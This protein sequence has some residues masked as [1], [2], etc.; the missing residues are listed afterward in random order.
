MAQNQ[1]T[2]KKKTTTTKRKTRRTP[3]PKVYIPAYKI[4]IFCAV[5]IT[6]C[7]TL[8]LAT[9]L[10]SKP[11]QTSIS[12]RYDEEVKIEK[13]V[14]EEEK[15]KAP[16]KKE[17]PKKETVKKETKKDESVKVEVPTE[18]KVEAPKKETPKPVEKEKT[19]AKPVTETKKPTP[20][21]EEKKD[22]G[23]PQA[24]NNAQLI[25]VF[26]DGGHSLKQ[27]EKFLDL[28]FPY[29]VAVLPR[30]KFSKETASLIRNSGNE[31]IL[32]QPMQAI[33]L[34]VDPG[35]GAITPDMTE[36][37]IIS[38]LFQNVTEIGPIAG[39]NNHEGSAI[40]A[41]AE[42]MATVL[43]FTSQEGIY[44]LDSRTNKDTAVPY[45]A[46][47]LGYSYYERNI[48]LDNEKTRDNILAE[49]RKG[50][51]IANKKGN[52]IM[53]GH[54]WSADILPSVLLEVYPELK[55]KG[56]TFSTVSKSNARIN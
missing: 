18:K 54:V 16:V 12:Q 36:S 7:M 28:P 30:L 24:V 5:I 17:E 53:I 43:R 51:G 27:A 21:K 35:P 44:F 6:V 47:E 14:I 32:H 48:F 55:A 20:P 22:F 19:E 56:Y 45:V 4:I 11:K 34:S 29:T 13:P 2:N 9:S 38:T 37:E 41:D 23:F 39:M 33:N 46:K 49:L 26:D 42:K 8:L 25:F 40:T 15:K 1:I 3:K 52:V 10:M 50:L 31:V